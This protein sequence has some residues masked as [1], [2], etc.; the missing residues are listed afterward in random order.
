[1]EQVGGNRTVVDREIDGGCIGSGGITS[2]KKKKDTEKDDQS[3][4]PA[5]CRQFSIVVRY[6]VRDLT[7]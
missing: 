4:I 3:P 2:T 1:M 5:L 6:E 7:E